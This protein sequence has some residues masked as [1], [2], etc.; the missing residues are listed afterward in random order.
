MWIR[1]LRIGG[2]GLGFRFQGLQE[3]GLRA[4][5]EGGFPDDSGKGCGT[6][7]M[8]PSALEPR[9]LQGFLAGID[10]G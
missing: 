8:G 2:L 5:D 6:L 9:I 3:L 10:S 4:W 7:G 1:E